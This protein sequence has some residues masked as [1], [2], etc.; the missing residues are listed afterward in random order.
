MESSSENSNNSTDVSLN[1][2][3]QNYEDELVY[4][5]PDIKLPEFLNTNEKWNK[6]VR[7]SKSLENYCHLIGRIT[8]TG[9]DTDEKCSV[10][11][12]IT[13]DIT[14]YHRY[15]IPHW[16]LLQCHVFFNDVDIL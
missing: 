12:H 8:H 7:E 5:I 3:S 6:C 1:N 14:L 13:T 10:M 11:F 15:L 9:L 2:M 16:K 4:N